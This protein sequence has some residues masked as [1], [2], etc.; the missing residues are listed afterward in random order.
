MGNEI[1][2]RDMYIIKLYST[3]V[4]IYLG[5]HL[6]MYFPPILDTDVSTNHTA[7]KQSIYPQ[8]GIFYVYVV[9]YN[10]HHTFYNPQFICAPVKY[11]R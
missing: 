5:H 6:Y 10:V 4:H 2:E 7:N 9:H 3:F 1:V 8:I 11:Q